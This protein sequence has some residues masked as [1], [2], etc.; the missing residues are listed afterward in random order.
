VCTSHLYTT[1]KL[2]HLNPYKFT[3]VRNWTSLPTVWFCNCFMKA[4]QVVKLVH[5]KLIL[6]KRSLKWSCKYTNNT[7]WQMI[8]THTWWT[9]WE[10]KEITSVTRP[11]VLGYIRQ[12]PWVGS[13]FS[14]TP[15]IKSM[16]KN[17]VTTHAQLQYERR[18]KRWRK[19]MS[20]EV[21]NWTQRMQ[22]TFIKT[23]A[24]YVSTRQKIVCENES[25]PS[26][27]EYTS[28]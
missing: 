9:Q 25:V 19:C 26:E 24:L 20:S 13:L 4:Y 7:G 27:C 21:Q 23:C 6:Q 3:V 14:W 8:H 12:T 10:M 18:G 16:P 2:L 22:S 11:N 5:C 17:S 1:T 15:S 28:Q